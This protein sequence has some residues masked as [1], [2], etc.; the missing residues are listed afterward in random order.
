[1]MQTCSSDNVAK[2]VFVDIFNEL[3]EGGDRQK[4]NFKNEMDLGKYWK[5]LTKIEGNGIGKGRFAQKL[6]AR[7]CKEHIPPYVKKAIDYIYEKVNV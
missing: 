1:M 5:C 4:E 7:V 3:T 6:S 2:Q